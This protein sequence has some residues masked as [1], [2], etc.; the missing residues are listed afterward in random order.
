MYSNL[1]KG[2]ALSK[3]KVYKPIQ[4]VDVEQKEAIPTST[5]GILWAKRRYTNLYKKIYFGQKEG[6]PNSTNGM[7]WA[8]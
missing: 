2:N 8:K 7:L 3:K 6:I 4:V 1:Y 5:K